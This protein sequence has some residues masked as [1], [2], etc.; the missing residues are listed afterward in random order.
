MLIHPFLLVA[1]SDV[2][3]W[4]VYGCTLHPYREFFLMDV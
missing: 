3:H 1:K 4:G 2:V